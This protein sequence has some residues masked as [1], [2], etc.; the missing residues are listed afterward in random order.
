MKRSYIALYEKRYVII[1]LVGGLKP[2]E[3]FAS[4]IEAGR[5][6]AEFYERLTSD[7]TCADMGWIWPII[8]VYVR[9]T[10]NLLA[11]DY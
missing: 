4:S 9:A 8:Y 3:P 6:G 11:A 7:K 10:D 1:Y 2:V 5:R